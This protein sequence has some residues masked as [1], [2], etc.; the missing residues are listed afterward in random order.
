V[1]TNFD[2]NL[3]HGELMVCSKR[4]G[5]IRAPSNY[6]VID[7]DRTSVLGNPFPANANHSNRDE[8]C[9]LYLQ[10]LRRQWEIKNKVVVNELTRL[11]ELH[12]QGTNLGLRCW[13]APKR[14][15]CDSIIEAI[16]GI[17]RRMK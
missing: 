12:V 6:L 13:C 17:A 9:D 8:V 11:V 5:G 16:I 14:C 7:C 10:W 4:K 1:R 2:N 15:H 3:I